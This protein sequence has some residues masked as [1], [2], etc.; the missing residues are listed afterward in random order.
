[1]N[2]GSSSVTGPRL[3]LSCLKAFFKV[4]LE[5]VEAQKAQKASTPKRSLQLLVS[6]NT[7]LRFPISGLKILR[8]VV[9]DSLEGHSGMKTYWHTVIVSLFST[10]S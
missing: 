3:S 2:M 8:H 5:N 10:L 4:G 9:H 1:M 6:T 7:C